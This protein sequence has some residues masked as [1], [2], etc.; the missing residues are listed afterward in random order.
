MSEIQKCFYRTSIKALILDDQKRF[1]LALEESGAWELPGGGLDFG[2]NPHDCLVREIKE[3]MGLEVTYMAKQPSYFVTTL[4]L[5][6]M[7]KA[8]VLY[9]TKVKDLNFT[10]SN[11]CIGVKFFTKEEA[12]KENLNP[13][14]QEFIKEFDPTN[15]I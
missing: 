14:V 7:Y 15:H 12:I 13:I 5:N 4:I 3:E 9:E 6:N 1:L 2:E 11:E 8:N 10:P